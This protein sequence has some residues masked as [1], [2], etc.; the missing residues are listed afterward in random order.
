MNRPAAVT[1]TVLGTELSFRTEDPEYIKQLAAFVENEIR[2]VV[3]SGKIS[4]QTKA[5]ILAAFTMADEL[6]RLRKEKEQVS[7]RIESMLEMA[8]NMHWETPAA[9]PHP[10]TE[11]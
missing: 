6:F 9:P 8:S 11:I 4:S 1:V 10:A 5:V 7:K 2:T 3:D